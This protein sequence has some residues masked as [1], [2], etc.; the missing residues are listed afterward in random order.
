[1]SDD[2]LKAA[3]ERIAAL[4]GDDE[5]PERSPTKLPQARLYLRASKW[6]FD[7]MVEHCHQGAAYVFHII[8]TLTLLRS[9]PL[10]LYSHDRKISATHEA[11]ITEWWSRMKPATSSELH[12]LKRV[13]DV[14][15]HDGAL[16]TVAVSSSAMIGGGPESEVWSR[17]YEVEFVDGDERHDLLA[18]LREIFDWVDAQL[19][20]IEAKLPDN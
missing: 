4:M 6:G 13:R 8:G 1:M 17:D 15:L 3:G 2:E 7:Q 12:F 14:A 19:S 10:A 16:N 9:V 20:E 5:F 18:K 11:V